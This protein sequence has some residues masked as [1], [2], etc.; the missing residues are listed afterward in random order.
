MFSE[1]TMRSLTILLVCVLTFSVFTVTVALP[2][3]IIHHNTGH[4]Y[5]CPDDYSR[6]QQHCSA[7]FGWT[8]WCGGVTR[9]ECKCRE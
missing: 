7:T 3:R 6:C 9:G 1:S 5:G 2:P 8:G 4:A